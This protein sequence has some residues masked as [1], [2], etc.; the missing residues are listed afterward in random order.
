[1]S[2]NVDIF[3]SKKKSHD[4]EYIQLHLPN[5]FLT[6]R[7]K[8]NKRQF[9]AQKEYEFSENNSDSFCLRFIYLIFLVTFQILSIS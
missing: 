6:L 7:N 8:E 1:M 2:E 5:T 3:L 4:F 9:Y